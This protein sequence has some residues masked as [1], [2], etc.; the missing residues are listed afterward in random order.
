MRKIRIIPRLDIK[1]PNL[2]KGINMEG[3]RV[4]GKPFQ[5]AKSYYEEGADELILVDVVASLYGRNNLSNFVSETASNIFIP[6]TVGGGIR[7]T[8]DVRKLLKSG[9]DK[10]SLNTAAIENP[11]LINDLVK[12]YGSSTI[13]VSCEVI[14]DS[15]GKY[16]LFT[17]NGREETNLE[18]TSWIEK[19]IDLGAGEIIV[20]DILKEGTGEGF[21]Y[22]L[23]EKVLKVCKVPLLIHGGCRT[24][25]DVLDVFKKFDLSGIVISSILHYDLIDRIKTSSDDTEGNITFLTNKSKY[26]NFNIIS[27]DN[28]KSYLR[29]NRVNV[30]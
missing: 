13:S 27:M 21:D 14:K 8:D 24:K 7:N 20:T 22:N 10:V 26:L 19:V 16:N 3:L 6:I 12:T 4:L 2:V 11:N 1:G 15:M 25:E 9:A 5:F 18:L 29:K 28:L 17:D 30:R 23:I